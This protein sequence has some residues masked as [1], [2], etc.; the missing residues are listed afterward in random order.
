MANIEQALL[1][2]MQA[3]PQGRCACRKPHLAGDF[4]LRFRGNSSARI[5]VVD[6][7]RYAS[8]GG[9]H[10]HKGLAGS[11]S[12]KPDFFTDPIVAKLGSEWMNLRINDFFDENKIATLSIIGCC[13][14]DDPSS[15]GSHGTCFEELYVEIKRNLPN[16]MLTIPIGGRSIR[17][18]LK[19]YPSV[20]SGMNVTTIVESFEDF[21]PGYFPMIHPYGRSAS[22]HM[23]DAIQ[24][25]V[26]PALRD[27]V[28]K[29]LQAQP[30][31]KAPNFEPRQQNLKLPIN[32]ARHGQNES[33]IQK[34]S[35][36]GFLKRLF[37][38]IFCRNR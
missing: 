14:H 12:K 20:S 25:R 27:E 11:R 30:K 28:G 19:Q 16:L 38:K 29:A 33:Q 37:C 7:D 8:T 4:E 9:G 5:L 23:T 17:H 24:N 22:M 2:I 15:G 34:T 1:K 31:A 36:I 10:A 18:V 35:L 26:L 21:L 13:V 6:Y 32:R 3:P